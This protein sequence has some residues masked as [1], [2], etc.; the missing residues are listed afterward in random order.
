M[1]RRCL[2]IVLG[3]CTKCGGG[4]AKGGGGCAEGGRGCAER[5][6]EVVLKVVDV[7]LKVIEAVLASVRLIILHAIHTIS[8]HLSFP[9]ATSL[10]LLCHITCRPS[11]LQSTHPLSVRLLQR[12]HHRAEGKH[13][14]KVRTYVFAGNLEKAKAEQNQWKTHA[15]PYCDVQ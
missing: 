1:W 8:V 15:R 3:G 12:Y 2:E 14:S 6:L 7:V 13:P 11:A 9:H 4:Y 10:T 5:C